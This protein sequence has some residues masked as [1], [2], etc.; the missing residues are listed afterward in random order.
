[1][2][3]PR[4][5]TGKGRVWGNAVPDGQAEDGGHGPGISVRTRRWP[6]MLPGIT[7]VV[8]SCDEKSAVLLASGKV[9]SKSGEV[10]VSIIWIVVFVACMLIS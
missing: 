4:Q 6:D 10:V 1:M 5:R 8:C 2:I 9:R 7:E 3:R